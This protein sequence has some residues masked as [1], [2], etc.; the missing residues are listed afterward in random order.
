[1]SWSSADT[2]L[3]EAAHPILASVIA[4]IAMIIR[5]KFTA[6][7]ITKFASVRTNTLAVLAS[8]S[9]LTGTITC[10]T[11]IWVRRGIDT[12]GFARLHAGKANTSAVNTALFCGALVSTDTTVFL[13]FEQRHAA[14]ARTK[15][16]APLTNTGAVL[17]ELVI[18]TLVPTFPTVLCMSV[19]IEAAIIAKTLAVEAL[20]HAINTRLSIIA[21]AVTGPTVILIFLQVLV[22]PI[23]L[24]DAG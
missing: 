1:M 12:T 21:R 18:T 6:F 3:F 24:R 9:H 16:T 7:T 11:T 5:A 23:A 15:S 4:P 17:A 13:V 20:A 22:L 14:R 19:E 8:L 2:F 10:P